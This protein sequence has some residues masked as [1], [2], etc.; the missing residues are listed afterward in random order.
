VVKIHQIVFWFGFRSCL[1]RCVSTKSFPVTVALHTHVAVSLQNILQS[2]STLCDFFHCHIQ[3]SLM[4]QSFIYHE[5]LQSPEQLAKEE[6]STSSMQIL[7]LGIN[8]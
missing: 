1:S 2:H 8:S 6:Q 5:G 4:N 3:L 7:D